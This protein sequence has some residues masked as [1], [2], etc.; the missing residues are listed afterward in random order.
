MKESIHKEYS[1]I[2]KITN[3]YLY[4]IIKYIRLE[5]S[6]LCHNNKSLLKSK[7]TKFTLYTL[8]NLTYLYIRYIKFYLSFHI[9]RIDMTLS[10]AYQ[11]VRACLGKFSRLE[12]ETGRRFLLAFFSLERRQNR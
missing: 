3:F 5:R 2:R 7:R 1:T 12:K 11:P 10:S 9:T 8:T 6:L 4:P